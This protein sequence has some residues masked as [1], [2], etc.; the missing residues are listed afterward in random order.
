M[1]DVVNALWRLV[2]AMP[3][4]FPSRSSKPTATPAPNSPKV[5]AGIG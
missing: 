2:R 1:L 5:A 4:R 3:D